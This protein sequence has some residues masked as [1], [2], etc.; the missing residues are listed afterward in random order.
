MTMKGLTLMITPYPLKI[1]PVNTILKITDG[2]YA[3]WKDANARAGGLNN[4]PPNP[5]PSNLLWRMSR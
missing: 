3:M 2:A 1:A 4:A 5:R